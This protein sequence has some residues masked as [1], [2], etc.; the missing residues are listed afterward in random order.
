MSGPRV[1]SGSGSKQDY[2]TPADFMAAVAR[3][4][5]TPAFD[6]AAHAGNRQFPRYYAPPEFVVKVERGETDLEALIADVVRAGADPQEAR[7]LAV[8]QWAGIGSK[9]KIVVPNR[10]GVAV[11][12]DALH[13]DRPHR[14][15]RRRWAGDIDDGLGWLNCEFADIDP[16]ADACV[17]NLREDGARSL[18]LT[19]AVF[20]GWHTA[21]VVGVADV[22]ELAGR[23]CFDGKSP[24]PKDC[25][26][27]HFHP[28]AT[29]KVC[30]WDWRR[31]VIVAEWTKSIPDLGATAQ[32]QGRASTGD[33]PA[34][35]RLSRYC[36]HGDRGMQNA[37]EE[38]PQAEHR[39][40]TPLGVKGEGV[41]RPGEQ[42]P[43]FPISHAALV[44]MT[45]AEF[46]AAAQAVI[47]PRS[48]EEIRE[49]IADLKA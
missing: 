15:Q 35:E 4:F 12:L 46:A 40:A 9:G 11:A 47:A 24:F 36:P 14:T 20:A 42:R 3:R 29:G 8:A 33:T 19:P 39:R 49:I 6:L 1:T 16:W 44:P 25:R 43:L 38:A 2:R 48:D 13:A 28:A 21:H 5:G 45:G 30:I 18:L 7:R 17:W 27:S 23:L 26:L 32:G 10:D 34:T 22:Y 41:T 31:D 37:P